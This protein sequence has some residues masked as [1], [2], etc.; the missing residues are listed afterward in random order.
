MT[1]RLGTSLPLSL[2]GPSLAETGSVPAPG[3]PA[4]PRG[5]AALINPPDPSSSETRNRWIPPLGLAYIASVA[6]T[7]QF[8][9]DLFDFSRELFLSA[10][11]LEDSGCFNYAVYGISSYSETWAA[12]VE[13]I[14]KIRSRCPTAF[15]VVGGYH[16][17]V[18]GREVLESYPAID[19]VVRNEGEEAFT[20][21]LIALSEERTEFSHIPGVIWRSCQQGIVSNEASPRILDVNQ[22]PFPVLDYKY[23]PQNPW[24]F[25]LSEEHANKK[26]IAI[27]SSRGCPKRCSFCSIIVLSPN[28]RLRSV[29]SLMEEIRF[30]YT[31]EP[32]T[33]IAFMDANFFV[34]VSRSVTFAR[35]L[36]EFN[37][38][39]TW[40]GTATADQIRRHAEVLPELGALNC[41]YLEVGIESGNPNSL[42]RF[43]KKTSVADNEQA[44]ALL[45]AAKIGLC[46]DFIMFDPEMTWEDFLE[47]VRFLYKSDLFGYWPCEF[48]FQELRLFAGTRLRSVYEERLKV[49]FLPHEM[50]VTPFFDPGV[51]TAW[52]CMDWYR[53][54]YHGKVNQLIRA[55][56]DSLNRLIFNKEASMSMTPSLIRVCQEGHLAVIR[57]KHLAY[58]FLESL[59]AM[60]DELLAESAIERIVNGID[61][62]DFDRTIEDGENTLA[63]LL[64]EAHESGLETIAKK[65][66][67]TEYTLR[68]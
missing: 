68:F 51:R 21:V 19:L 9:V 23:Y 15:I 47:N 61:L 32:F 16:A 64:E 12:T 67:R 14:A 17:S 24:Y 22:L 62:V 40:S 44:I 42:L 6:R 39:I 13:M 49:R 20:E 29:E 25:S 66:H 41:A 31:I 60:V 4:C 59:L 63:R 5:R 57:L 37:P 1:S 3:N 7:H 27:V 10:Q 56:S 54:E 45:R 8:H 50:P 26:A 33:H 18:V 58:Q 36:Y 28:Y 11:T 55:L 2:Q 34:K 53:H 38:D 52:R 43:N 48:I 30:R 46:F 65:W 35:A